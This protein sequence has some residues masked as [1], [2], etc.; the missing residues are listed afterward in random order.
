MCVWVFVCMHFVDYMHYFF[1]VFKC[2]YSLSHMQDGG[3]I[4]VLYSN[5]LMRAGITFF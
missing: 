4:S 1:A 3:V 2:L 5:I